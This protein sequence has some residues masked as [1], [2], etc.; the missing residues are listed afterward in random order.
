[1][2]YIPVGGSPPPNIPFFAFPGGLP[3]PV[4]AHR[5]EGPIGPTMAA[6]IFP[7]HLRVGDVANVT[8][9]F[10]GLIQG[11]VQVKFQGSSWLSPS[12]QGPFSASVLVPPDAQTGVCEIEI[13]GRRVFGAQCIIDPAP[14]AGVG[15]HGKLARRD[16]WTGA[17]QLVRVGQ[18]PGQRPLVSP[19]F[20]GL[21]VAE[22]DYQIIRKGHGKRGGRYF[23]IMAGASLG[24]EIL[25]SMGVFRR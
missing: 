17:G 5:G 6:D 10:A 13:N 14:G 24:I 22:I 18:V 2:S 4:P 8:G 3:G 25:Y 15:T 20:G 11:Q 16:E 9:P 21:V 19:F 1:M 7:K 23:A 12:M